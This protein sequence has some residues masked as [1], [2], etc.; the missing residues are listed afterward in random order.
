MKKNG[1]LRKFIAMFLVF[2]MLMADSS[3]TTFA[4]VVG[5]SVQQNNSDNEVEIN[6]DENEAENQQTVYTYEDSNVTVT[7]TLAN[8]DA[9]PD[10]AKFIVTK[11]NTSDHKDDYAYAEQKL[12]EYE[13]TENVSYDKY[14]IYDMHF[15]D[16]DGNEIEPAEGQVSVNISYKKAQKL[17]E[18][19]TEDSVQVLHLDENEDQLEDVT[20]DVNLDNN[21]KLEEVTL[22]TENFSTFIIADQGLSSFKLKLQFLDNQGNPVSSQSGTYY[23]KIEKDGLH[24]YKK[25]TVKNGVG[26]ATFDALYDNN[27]TRQKSV[28]TGEYTAILAMARPGQNPNVEGQTQNNWDTNNALSE[29][30]NGQMFSYQFKIAIEDRY[31]VDSDH[32]TVVINATQI[33]NG[34]VSYTDI[35]DALKDASQFMVVANYFE[36]SMHFEGNFAANIFHGKGGQP[37]G[38]QGTEKKINLTVNIEKTVTPAESKTFYFRIVDANNHTIKDLTITTNDKGIG[39]TSYTIT[40]AKSAYEVYELDGNN[41]KVL[42]NGEKTGDYKVSYDYSKGLKG[43]LNYD[44]T[45]FAKV[46][47]NVKDLTVNT[48]NNLLVTTSDVTVDKGAIKKVTEEEFDS[49]IDIQGILNA[50]SK[51]SKTLATAKT[52]DTAAVVYLTPKDLKQQK[53]MLPA[54]TDQQALVI[55]VMIPKGTSEVEVNSDE[56]YVG[57]VIV[58]V[59]GKRYSEL[60]A[61]KIGQQI[62]K[63]TIWNF[64]YEDGSSYTG[65]VKD[66]K[67]KMGGFALVPKG[68]YMND[69]G[70]CSIFANRVY[71][72]GSEIHKNSFPGD[73]EKTGTVKISNSKESDTTEVSVKKVW[74]DSNNQDGLRTASITVQLYAGNDAV[75]DAVTLDENNKWTYTWEGLAKKAGG[76]EIEYR[77]DEV[78]VPAG[79]TKTVTADK[80]KTSY[81]ITNTHETDKTKISVEKKWEDSSNQDGVRPDSI[82]VQLYAGNDAVGDAVTLDESNKWTYTWEGLAKKAGGKE[83]EYRVDEVSVPAGY[84][85]TVTAD[86][87]KTS[88]VITNTHTPET[89]SVSG[90]KTWDDGNN[91]DGIRP[92]KITVK[93]FANGDE[94]ASQTV[95]PDASGNWNYSFTNLPKYANASEITYTVTEDVVTGYETSI[96]GYNITNTHTPEATSISGTKNWNDGNNQD[97]K[98]PTSITVKL[99][100]N[101]DEYASQTVTPDANG[102]WKYSFTNVPKYANGQEITYTVEETAVDGY[103]STVKGYDITNTYTPE[104][105]EV[106]GTKTWDDND[107]QDGKRPTSITVN[108]YAN[109]VYNQSKEVSADASGNW[110][111]SFTDLP[112][113]ANGSEITYTV[114]ENAVA[115]Y[116]TELNGYNIKNSHTP[117]T[118]KV[119]GI[120]TWK[121]AGNQDG[122]RPESITVK[123]LANGTEKKSQEVSAKTNWKYSFTDLPKY[124][125]GQEIVYTVVE[126]NVEG[127]T[128]EYDTAAITNSYTPGKTSATVKKIWNDAGNQDGKRPTSITV[129]LYANEKA[130]ETTAVLNK[131]NNWS[132]TVADLDEKA[133]GK[134]IEYTWKEEKVP[135]GY[136][137]TEAT[138]NGTTTL[139][140]AHTPETTEI[141][142]SKIWNDNDNQDGIRPDSITVKLLAN[143]EVVRTQE[144]TKDDDW[145][146][147]FTDLPKYA[148]G[149]E[150]TYTVEEEAV[151]GYEAAVDGYDITN[152][153]TTEK[154]SIAGSKTWKDANNQDGIRPAE[155]TVNLLADGEQIQSKTV[156][157][158]DNWKYKFTDLPKY[159][160]GKEI[161][162]TVTEE[163]VEGY[164]IAVNGYNITNTHTPETTEVSGNKIWDDANNQDGIR[165]AEIIVNLLADGEQ[166]Q[167][168][169]VTADNNWAYSFTDLPKYAKGIEIVY[170]VTEKAVEGYEAKV[171]GNNITNTHTPE[172]TEVNGSKTWDDNDN[173]DGKRPEKIVINLLANDEVVR[174]QEVTADNNWTYSFT[175]LP[176]YANGQEIE[177]TVSEAAVA[178]YTASYDGFNITNTHTPGKVSASVKKVWND[179]DN[180]DGKRPESITVSLLADGKATGTTVT[181]NEANKWSDTVTDLPEK[182]DGK[183]IVYTWEEE[184]VPEG[185]ELTGN[186]SDGTF[187]V[188]TNTHT[189]ETTKVEGTKTW[190]DSDNQDGIRPDSITVNLFA[191][192]VKVKSQEVTV[193]NNWKY[194]FDDLDKYENGKEII[195][196]VGEDLVNGYRAIVD[197]YNITNTHDTAKTEVSGIKTWNDGNDQDGIRPEKITVNL[198]AD[199][200]KVNTQEVKPDDNGNWTYSFTD[201]PKFKAGK[202]IVYTVTE[203]A[204]EGYVSTVSG[205]N[206]NNTHKPETIAING[207]KHWDDNDDQDGKRPE[208]ITVNLLANGEKV[209]SQ[210]VTAAGNWTYNFT[211]LP[212]YAEGSEI[213]YTVEEVA[214][215]GYTTELDGYDIYNTHTP[216][217]TIVEGT[218]SWNDKDDQDGKRPE[219][220]IVNLLANGEKVDTQVVTADNDWKYSFKDLPV[221]KDGQKLTYTVS[222]ET[223]KDYTTEYDGTNIINSYTPGKTSATVVKVWNDADNQD[224]KRPESITVSLLADGKATGTTVTLN[225]ENNWTQTVTDLD[226]KANGKA[227]EY[228]WTEENIPEGYELTG[229]TADGTVTTLTN[230]Y[231]PETTAISGSK[232]WNDANDQDGKRPESITVNLLANGEVTDS[233]TVTAATNWT[234]TFENLPVY[235]N[236]QKITYTVSENEVA[237]YET[238]IDGFNI[239]NSY[240][241]ETTSVSGKKVWN[242]ANNQDGKRPESITVR[243]FAN[244]TEVANKEVTAADDWTYSFTD[245]PKY[246]NGEEI[247]YTVKEDVVADYTTTIDGTTITNSYTPG[248]TSITVTKAWV[249]NDNQDGIRP[250]SIKVQLYAGDAV[251]GKEITLNAENKWTYTWNDLDEKKDGQDISYTVK[252]VGEV[253]GYT[254]EISGD[255]QTGYVITNTH[256]PETTSVEGQ[257]VWDDADNQDGK[258]P[259]SITVRLLADGKET[260]VKEVTAADNWAYSFTELPKFADG[261][262]IV[263]TVKEDVVADYTTTINGTTITNSYK[264]GKTSITV[265]KAWVDNDNQDGIRPESI[266]VQLYAGDAAQGKEV[267]L[268]AE[269]KWTYTW[270]DLDEKKGG[271]DIVYTVRETEVPVGY[272]ATVTGNAAEGFILTNTHKTEVISVEGTKTWNDNDQIAKRP[273]SITVRLLADGTEVNSQTVNAESNWTYKFTDLPK[274]AAGKEIVYTVSEDAVPGYITSVNGT[275]LINTITSVK[276]S[277]VD[278]T[279]HK[280]L[281]GAHI[282]VIDKDGNIVDEWDSTWESHE[283]TGLKTG[284][285]YI[286]RETVAPDGYTVTSDTTFTLKEDGTVDK[287]NTQTTVSDDGT[288]LVEDSKT[289][290]RVS[291]V[292]I[293][294]GK[295]L[296]GAHIQILDEDENI[297]DEWDSTKESHVIEGLKTGK[298]YT[299]RETVA[300]TGYELTSDTTFVL[301]ADGTVDAENTTTVSKDGVLLVQDK[302]ATGQ[303]IAVTK[304]LTTITGDLKA[305]DQTF[306]VALYSDEACTQRVSDVKAIEFKNASSSTVVF[307][308]NIEVNKDYYIAECSQDGTAQSMGALADGTMYEAKFND[309]N[310]ATVKEANGTTTVYF[311]NVFSSIPDGYY[312]Q[313]KIT[314]TKKLLG[315]DGNAKKSNNVFYAGIFDDA[316]HTQLSTQVQ[317]NIVKLDL[318]GGSEVSQVIKV[319]LDEN[320]AVTLY[321]T[322][323]DSNGK[324]IAGTSGFAYKV[325]VDGS[326][327]TIDEANENASVTITNTENPTTTT[328][329]TTEES[330]NSS[331]ASSHSMS[332]STKAP[333][334]GDNTPIAMYVIILI[335]AVAL[336]VFAFAKRRKKNQK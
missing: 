277:K 108:L 275:N 211:D 88:Y 4:D 177:Y 105:T 26:E 283:V 8:A 255:A 55:N 257:K 267:T 181:L 159:A 308:E 287:D 13:Q 110:T 225:A 43:L 228:T 206:I 316:D 235:A 236:G 129:R 176:K 301:K 273:E 292:D 312:K 69:N 321:V 64:V 165:P 333:K 29:I 231:A 197:D 166:I 117:E 132:A 130:T 234:Y 284:E 288:L 47:E 86:K 41:G 240:T 323:T 304:K 161:V 49:L 11:M 152:N 262:E 266:K 114:T 299:L 256:T 296:E 310:K 172:T 51:L 191:N 142:G 271:K 127:Y 157:A 314:I 50:V 119:E 137:L 185:Y 100:A 313:G 285:Q 279:D 217:T 282:Q 169:T 212:K 268:N 270:N 194:T 40:D 294:D 289:S 174:S 332:S 33:G 14:L 155:I 252:E 200:N 21:G 150:I 189:P 156:T 70:M 309:G 30:D 242:D 178:D 183:A 179:N 324:P 128:T 286:L 2:V 163:A 46:I 229:N 141:S 113:Y 34:S 123:L 78:S 238:T 10:N 53:L 90:E 15:E 57:N 48:N 193:A 151:E 59:A 263:Y 182:A 125:N 220:I 31:T 201:L 167:S 330:N 307:D 52:T 247:V 54:I 134:A 99:L 121:D 72:G 104:T 221:Y 101:G 73:Q 274:Y 67:K 38:V 144:V 203:E 202:E 334:T 23:A 190:N 215:E 276:I 226:E 124:E 9:V 126:E 297:V 68:S 302:L 325:S 251:Q 45:S 213:E 250:G 306:Y 209:N 56:L 92:T 244:G 168:K 91:Q 259:E 89:T 84:T 115:N 300:P 260:A 188:I 233:Q 62:A 158:D 223:V 336:I 187:T 328:T 230:T 186:T 44:S 75:G 116:T 133:N 65:Y 180:Q 204:V 254:S 319:G 195:Y 112:K 95:T 24:Q 83:I 173:Q 16:A 118:T 7:V 58:D 147:N 315:A 1:Y 318:A 76:K 335:A 22:T 171:N 272:E 139:T 63:R 42:K 87:T 281:A 261:K 18:D 248:K 19:T 320:K 145:K 93:L 149:K 192:G 98:R 237:G 227:I 317:Q 17:S 303:T 224:G 245:L 322:E 207:S 94:Y 239:T 136:T 148:D 153:H 131:D 20:E 311:D 160:N 232:T 196:T 264:P 66:T 82:E 6:A 5:R 81:A 143:D 77:V 298:K 199:G 154:V 102:N 60:E 61:D 107:N 331:S 170:T 269:N 216:E 28:E 12:K 295:E 146:Y 246:A 25:L 205:Y 184:N 291:K 222:E 293:A 140:N 290:V 80:T 243:L 214:V 96:D 253:T 265:T 71:Q 258:R 208:S 3:M 74:E 305:M 103:T 219:K 329:T 175:D 218:K 326:T 32:D 210:V 39:K 85:K 138:E 79:Y 122:K 97:G 35:K 280:E 109:G 241:P 198:L 27:G 37:I 120:K 36:Q 164:E 111:Y 135:D 249:D 162:Y 106:S 327:V 278:I